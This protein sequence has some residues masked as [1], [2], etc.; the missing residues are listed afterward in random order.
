[1]SDD[2]TE[3]LKKALQEASITLHKIASAITA[4][5]FLIERPHLTETMRRKLSAD[6]LT[7]EKI[8]TL[9]ADGCEAAMLALAA[10]GD[11]DVTVIECGKKD[12]IP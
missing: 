1:M 11:P 2:T 8:E 7:D 6:T 10:A 12:I 5:R 4:R 9:A 3:K